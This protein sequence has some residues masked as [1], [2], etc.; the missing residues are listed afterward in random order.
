MSA[1]DEGFGPFAARMGG[2]G[3]P[4]VAIRNFAHHYAELRQGQSGTISEG[5]LEPVETLPDADELPPELRSLGRRVLP[6]TVV[7]KLNGG[8][9]TTMGLAKAK[10]LL[11]VREGRSFLEL[12]A[13]ACR[14]AK[15]PLV[16]MNSFATRDESLAALAPL[17]H[18]SADLPLDFL[19]H[20]VPK[21]NRDTLQPASWPANPGLEWCPPG[22]GDLYASMLSSGLLERLLAK[23]YEYAFVSNVD[24]LGAALD[25]TIL[26]YVSENRIPLL[27]EVT[28]RTAAD[29][30]GGHLARRP[31]GGLLLREAAQCAPEDR[32]AFGDIHRHRYF[33]T[34]SLWLELSTLWELLKAG[35]GVMDLPL[36]VNA[37]TVDPRDR[38]STP[39][40]QLETAMG[41]AIAVVEGAQAL[42]VPR[43]RFSPVKT[44]GD[45]LAVR[46]DAYQLTE[47]YRVVV[48]PGRERGPLDVVLDPAHY[49]HI[50]Q[51]EA[52][53][54]HGPPS[55]LECDRLEIRGDVRFGRGVRLVG[56]VVLENDGESPLL[57]EDGAVVR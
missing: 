22:H 26:G 24:N 42:R 50:D 12:T 25:E 45:L 8:L 37:K 55:L 29:R 53:F 52:R 28:E 56:E 23:G 36:I 34:N 40:Y 49:Q 48:N 39:V 46:S 47:D 7:I 57:V 1:F 2:A 11:E 4:D 19:Q 44:T 30:K 54:P 9:G 51:L 10:S 15:V 18:G 14:E 6:A 21:V 16:L 32:E 20:R 31:G 43:S 35:N 38:A 13:L 33:N 3:L 17:V 5:E 41:S 27:M